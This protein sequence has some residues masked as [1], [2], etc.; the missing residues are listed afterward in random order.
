MVKS[1]QQTNKNR[2]FTIVELLVVIV[3]IGILAAITLVSYTG[4]TTRAKTSA[5]QANANAVQNVAEAMNADNGFYPA[6]ANGSSAAY[7]LSGGSASTHVPSSVTLIPDNAT[8]TLV[9]ATNGANTIGYACL[10]TCSSS[11]G[12]RIAYW[13][14]STSTDNYVYVGAGTSA[15]TY[16]APAS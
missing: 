1:R 7:G 4:V 16:V 2:G 3:V 10:T 13:N 8:G 14:F 11:T 6:L 5:D 15:G 9:T 12:G